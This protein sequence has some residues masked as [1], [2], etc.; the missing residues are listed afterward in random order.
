MNTDPS[1]RPPDRPFPLV[2]RPR[3]GKLSVIIAVRNEEEAL[4][5]LRERLRAVL[6]ETALDWEVILVEDSSTDRTREVIQRA[7]DSD[8]R[9]KAIFL[10]RSFGH[11]IAL[12]AGLEFA[13]GDHF[14]FMD[15]DLQHRPEDIPRL[16]QAYFRGYDIVYGK[17]TSR[18]GFVKD[19]GSR[20]INWLVNCLSDFPI[21]LN[22][23]M[24]RVFS[25]R[26]RDH[27]RSMRERSRFLVGMISWLGFPS[28]EVEIHEDERRYGRSKYGLRQMVELALHYLTS[29]STRPLRLAAYLGL[30]TSGLS[31]L[32]GLFFLLQQL[33]LGVKVSGFPTIIVT[34]TM[35]GGA[36]LFVLGIMGEYLGRM[37]IELQG[38]Q[39]YVV[40]RTLNVKAGMGRSLSEGGTETRFRPPG[41]I[42]AGG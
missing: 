30:A 27:L 2:P 36:I 5:I 39:M 40:E 4:P 32:M 38:R 8:R 10:T 37:Y 18:Q 20:A 13:T 34:L 42:S 31:I 41:P 22:S 15:G 26:V 35:L 12:T 19:V 14:L 16:L 1:A 28:Y 33:I 24:F 21:D 11:H 9:F 7:C 25:R 6:T 29:F 3:E 17:R 23:G